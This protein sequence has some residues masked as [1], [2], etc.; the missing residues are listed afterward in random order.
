MLHEKFHIWVLAGGL[1]LLA[2]VVLRAVAVWRSVDEEASHAHSHDHDHDH[3]DGPCCGHD[4]D[5]PHHH[6]HGHGHHHHHEGPA[7]AIQ[8]APGTLTL[9]SEPATSH[10]PHAHHHDHGHEHGWAPWRYVVLLLPVVLYF[11]ILSNPSFDREPVA[12]MTNPVDYIQNFII[13]FRSIVWEALPFIILGAIIAGLLEELLPQQA[14]A[15]ILPRSRG[16]AIV[17]GALLGLVFPMCECGIVPVMRRLLRKGL[18]LSCC[19]AYLLAGPVINVVVLTSTYVA[20]WGMEN[21]YEG[22]RPSYQMGGWWMMGFRAGL[23]FIVAVVTALI[24]EWTHRKYGD[25]LLTPLARPS[26]PPGSPRRSSAGLPLV[27]ES[28]GRRR[29]LWERV[30]NISETALHDFVDITVF[31]IL[32]ALLSAGAGLLLTPERVAD[33]SREHIL[34]SILL[35]MALAV[36]LCLCSEADA[37]VAASF[38]TM[39][40]AAKLAFLVLGP[41]LD[42]KLY[43]MYTRV[44]RR[45]LIWT[46]YGSLI[47]QVLVYSYIVHFIWERYAPSWITPVQKTAQRLVPP[48]AA[49]AAARTV[50]LLSDPAGGGGP[51]LAAAVHVVQHNTEDVSEIGFLDL[52]MAAQSPEQRAYFEGKRVKLVGRYAGDDERRFGLIR[53]RINCCAADAVPLK[54]IIMIDPRSKE[55]LPVQKLNGHWVQVTGRVHFLTRPGTNFYLPALILS[56]TERTPLNKMVELVPP[57]ANPFLS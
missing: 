48:E 18:P 21:V 27:E 41:M 50:A 36:L 8:P 39:R 51:L 26:E 38:V 7:T 53:Y 43:M 47:V 25:D 35:M 2:L 44:F 23:A 37:F 31:L 29:S 19:V 15:R 13:R 42:L 33:L 55:V 54:S 34:L 11:L 6:D 14:I 17:M 1:S 22:G 30:S 45:R 28:A 52:E 16:L 5:H 20:F 3:G 46:I 9:A 12:T 4:H 40:P 56:P 49:A 10:A 24:V 32:G 57:P